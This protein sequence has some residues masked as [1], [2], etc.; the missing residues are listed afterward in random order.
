MGVCYYSFFLFDPFFVCL[1]AISEGSDINELNKKH[2]AERRALD[3]RLEGEEARQMAEMTIKLNEEHKE[4]VKQ[5]N[6][7]L[8]EK[9]TN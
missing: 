3:T 2:E 6:R 1:K 4:Q 5:A 8:F 9:V 7:E